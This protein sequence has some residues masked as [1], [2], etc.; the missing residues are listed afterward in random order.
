MFFKF[1]SE[2]LY[3][4]DRR[5]RGRIPQRTKCSPQ[6]V[7]RQIL[8]VVDVFH[9]AAAA[10]E[11]RERLLQPVGTFA[12]GNA[13]STAFV[14]VK[15]HRPQRELHNA[16]RVIDYDNTTRAEHRSGLGDGIKIH[17][18]VNFV[19]GQA[20]TRRSTG[21]DSLQ[22]AS[23]R[24][25]AAD[26][27]EHLLQVVAHRQFVDAGLGDVAAQAK[28][29]RAAVLRRAQLRK[30]ISTV[31]HNVRNVGQRL[32]IINDRRPAP[33]SNDGREGWP[34]AR[35]AALAFQRLHQRRLF[36]H[37]VSPGATVPVNVEGAAAAENILAAKSLGISIADRLLHDDRQIS[38]FAANVDVAAL[39]A[40]RQRRNHYALDHRMRIVLEDQ[41]V[42]ACA[43]LALIAIAQNIF[44]LGG[45]LGHER[46]LHAG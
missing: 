24:N 16:L 42:F 19:C 27:V 2:L 17:G 21:N 29:P 33:Q 3:K 26:V 38:I 36:A 41:T 37:F 20:W 25:T 1:F 23:I 12:A 22:F 31:K 30:P 46:P 5:H 40:D 15:L 14:L 43:R 6:H 8:H 10:M 44:R 9:H 45:L 7:L 32:S 4:G 28:Q 35:D 11:A 18:N 13:P 34:D 39:R